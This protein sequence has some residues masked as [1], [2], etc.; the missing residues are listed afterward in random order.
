[1]NR[2]WQKSTF[3]LPQGDN[4]VETRAVDGGG[5]EVRDSKQKGAGPVLTFTASEWDAFVN[6]VKA[7]EFETPSI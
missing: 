5:V 1:M 2:T 3:S 4:C 6:G 7:G